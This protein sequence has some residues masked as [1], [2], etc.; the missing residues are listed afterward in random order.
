MSHNLYLPD[1][2]LVA[3]Q[4]VLSDERVV[5]NF[6]TIVE[7]WEQG[8]L[9]ADV[10]EVFTGLSATNS[11]M[12]V[13][14]RQESDDMLSMGF[15]AEIINLES[16]K[17]DPRQ[18]GYAAIDAAD[19]AW[20]RLIDKEAI[21]NWPPPDPEKQEK[22]G[23]HPAYFQP[24]HAQARIE[25]RLDPGGRTNTARFTTTKTGPIGYISLDKLGLSLSGSQEASE[26]AESQ[27]LAA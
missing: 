17:P 7:G 11:L 26:L 15:A 23:W 21:A 9:P 24:A 8:G 18:I 27:A 20:L 25:L 4:L 1:K 19:R 14:R 5:D 16:G 3:G 10:D 12:R 22:T 13:I 2:S 6:Q